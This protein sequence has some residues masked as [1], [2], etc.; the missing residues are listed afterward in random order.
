[1]TSHIVIVGGGLAGAKTAQGLR[2]QGYAGPLTLIAAEPHLP[3]ERPPLSKDYL[4]GKSSFHDALALP[5]RDG[6]TKAVGQFIAAKVSADVPW[7]HV[8]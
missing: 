5:A 2:D 3:Y 1:M 8:W 4:M 7:H 6:L